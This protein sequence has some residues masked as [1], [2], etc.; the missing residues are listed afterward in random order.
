MDASANHMLYSRSLLVNG[1]SV[2]SAGKPYSLCDLSYV[3]CSPCK[4][5][6]GLGLPD[7]ILIDVVVL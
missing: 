1:R 5:F 7:G 4:P 6:E 2:L 3:V